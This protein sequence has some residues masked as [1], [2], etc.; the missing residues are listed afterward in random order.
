MKKLKKVPG[1]VHKFKLLFNEIIY[2]TEMQRF[3]HT[4]YSAVPDG[5]TGVAFARVLRVSGKE[6]LLLLGLMLLLLLL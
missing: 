1:T 2:L 3:R 6:L 4:V 5:Y